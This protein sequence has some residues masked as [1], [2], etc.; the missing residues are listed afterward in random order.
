ME[1][2]GF[3]AYPSVAS[4]TEVVKE[5]IKTVNGSGVVKISSWEELRTSG[6]T[7][8]N[9]ICEEIER[10]DLFLADLTYLNPNVLFE[11]GYA[12]ARNKKIVVFLDPSIE[13]AKSDFERFNLSTLGYL[14]YNNSNSMVENFFSEEPY[15]DLEKTVLNEI[16]TSYIEKN[17]GLLY[18]KSSIETQASIKLS[19]RLEKSRIKPL[20][21]DDPQ[22]IRMQV[23]KWYVENVYKS[24]AI[25][26]HL[27]SDQHS[28]RELHNAKVA[29]AVGLGYGFG[30]QVIMLA[31]E[32]Y[33]CPLDYR[34]LL[35]K[36]STATECEKIVET[37]LMDTEYSYLEEQKKAVTYV[38][39][40]RAIDSIKGIDIGDYVAEQES[41]RI[42]DYFIETAAYREALKSRYTIFIGR[43]GTG[44]SAILYELEYELAQ[45]IRNHTCIIKPIS[46]ELNGLIAILR[47]VE[48]TAEKGFLIESLWKY[49]IYTEI[50]KSIYDILENKPE[51]YE[52]T[53]YE[54]N[55]IQL[56]ESNRDIFLNDFSVR[57]EYVLSRLSKIGSDEKG[58]SQRLKVSE[59][60]HDS[61]ISK[62]R[63]L[64]FAYFQHKENVVVLIDNLDKTWKHGDDIPY[65]SQFIL[66]LLSVANRIADDFR[67][68][69][70]KDRATQFSIVI[71]LRTD[72]FTYIYRQAR[73]RD[74]IRYYIVSWDDPELLCQV[75]E[76]RFRASAEIRDDLD[77]WGKYFCKKVK[78]IDV[79]EY[80]VQSVLPR[81]RDILFFVKCALGNAVTRKHDK[82]LEN[83]IIDAQDRY[84]QHAIDALIVENGISIEDFENLLYEFVGSKSII[85]KTEIGKISLKSNVKDMKL[86]ELIE[87]L[88]E[89]CFLGRQV[90][91]RDF[92]YQINHLDKEKI[93]ALANKYND[94]KRGEEIFYEI[95]KAYRRYLEIEDV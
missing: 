50:A 64:L 57:L 81:P 84:S 61:L 27:I 1:E 59:I 93:V 43:K 20:I 92:R 17:N 91:E 25:V 14:P 83:D 36:H 2:T 41:E 45:D 3:F 18:L 30:K 8:I 87:L 54:N 39:L 37:W 77:I 58:V 70:K 32:P 80:I 60:L 12:I 5:F 89:R 51:Y 31:H 23:H 46:Y 33:I 13:K 79:K 44:K 78:G 34:H 28:G 24:F 9:S 73:E 94:V 65:L 88:C 4:I 76:E 67:F 62:L 86:D 42:H 6:L 82:I 71:F 56:I 38:A 48:G 75:I 69:E 63:D 53:E 74:K 95:N 26:G 35:Q 55:L 72:I 52:M 47:S 68:K 21:I 19:R 49:L 29:F 10:T 11:L 40:R 90:S 15:N 22:E 66:G 85:S 7:I 16:D